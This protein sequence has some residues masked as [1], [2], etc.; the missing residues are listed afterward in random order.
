MNNAHIIFEILSEATRRG[1]STLTAAEKETVKNILISITSDTI[2][3]TGA[4]YF[5][6]YH[7]IS[8]S[9][10]DI[11]VLPEIAQPFLLQFLGAIS[12]RIGDDGK[13][14]P[15]YTDKLSFQKE[16]IE[17]ILK[18]GF[19]DMQ[20]IEIKLGDAPGGSLIPLA[21]WE[22]LL[23]HGFSANTF[24]TIISKA[25]RAYKKIAI[26]YD[27]LFDL[28]KQYGA[29][30]NHRNDEG[31]SVLELALEEGNI[32]IIDLLL[33][34]DG[35]NKA[36]SEKSYFAGFKDKSI[37]QIAEL[38]ARFPD[39]YNKD[40]L[41]ELE[42]SSG[43]S[44]KTINLWNDMH[45]LAVEFNDYKKE[46]PTSLSSEELAIIDEKLPQREVSVYKNAP[47]HNKYGFTP[48]QLALLSDRLELA[49][50]MIKND[51][52]LTET[53]TNECAALEIIVK[54]NIERR[55]GNTLDKLLS[56][57]F[58]KVDNIDIVSHDGESFVDALLRSEKELIDEV[59]SKS[60]DPLFVF[61][62]NGTSLT[63]PYKGFD[64]KAHIGIS[65]GEHFWSSGINSFARL[66]MQNNP[67]MEFHLVTQDMLSKGGDEFIKQFNGWIN[68]GSGDSYPRGVQEFDK[69]KWA[70]ELDTE[71]IYQLMLDKTLEFNIPITGMCAGAQNLALYHTGY[72]YPLEGYTTF[73]HTMIYKEGTLA[74]YHAMTAMQ[75][76][77]ALK[78]CE[79]PVIQFK[80]DTAHHFAAV[81]DK[82]GEGL[83][84]GAVSEEGVPMAFVHDNG[85]R[86]ATQF[87]PEH[88]YADGTDTNHQKSWLDN[89]AKLA[90]MHYD[91]MHNNGTHPLEYMEQVKEA[92]HKCVVEE[93]CSSNANT[94]DF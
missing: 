47:I 84:L 51:F 56:E 16:I 76:I 52:S 36:I 80:G 62:K 60:N 68:P 86:S 54:F 88:F 61:F 1:D 48:L 29:D 41:Y 77:T 91:Y 65:H 83:E 79:F 50:E 90:E 30:L 94:L 66:M 44:T 40:K 71:Q 9:I 57:A 67:K 15:E 12:P 32:K 26:D 49:Y 78:T 69:S 59:I 2:N 10:K 21:I 5:L 28:A 23:S 18:S 64:Q 17:D 70:Q 93:V 22:A 46:K 63:M 11:F 13:F 81:K 89:F 53:N 37:M 87:H 55:T 34:E 14:Y 58:H 39:V 72:L 24:L 74:H 31:S 33:T 20:K 45:Q 27:K 85:I 92:L 19:F 7:E 25:D 4:R 75:Q 73:G 38:Q 35:V 43:T 3:T 8:S 42:R 82:L 6:E